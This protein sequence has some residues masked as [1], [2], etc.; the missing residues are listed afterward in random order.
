MPL[1]LF[2]NNLFSLMVGVAST[3]I[4]FLLIAPFHFNPK[5]QEIFRAA[6]ISLLAGL[7]G[8]ILTFWII[9]N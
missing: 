7:A 5:A 6:G 4:I 9:Q 3:L 8:F 2:S 1:T